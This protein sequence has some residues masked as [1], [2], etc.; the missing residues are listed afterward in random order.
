LGRQ[1]DALL[2][3]LISK[4]GAR[5]WSIIAHGIRGRSGKSCRLRWCN[6]LN[7]S[8]KKEPFSEEEDAKIVQVRAGWGNILQPWVQTH[9]PA[10]AQD[11]WQQVGHYR[12]VSAG[13]VREACCA[14]GK[15]VSDGVFSGRTTLSRTTGAFAGAVLAPQH[16]LMRGA[17]TRR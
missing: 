10:G 6:Q 17:G 16:D 1:E 3:Q 9:A 4:H 7:P 8:V 5:N 12:A 13:Q 11:V 2:R 14:Q 15:R